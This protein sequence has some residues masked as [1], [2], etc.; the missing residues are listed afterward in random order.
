LLSK[1]SIKQD[2][3]FSL[4]EVLLVLALIGVM[5]AIVAGNAGAFIQA[6]SFEPPVRV[7]KKAV[8]D[9]YYFAGERK[10]ATFL[11]YDEENASFMVSDVSGKILETHSVFKN[12]NQKDQIESDDFPDVQF[13]AV[14]PLSGSS[15]GNTIY[16]ENQLLLNRIRFHS[17]SSVAFEASIRHRGE[18]QEF[19]FD[20][21]SGF[22]LSEK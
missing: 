16:R 5:A 7:L 3:G 11:S 9:A 2:S 17:G 15:G 14:G 10:E 4:I 1:I 8:L 18:V 12:L 13:R 21:F 6:G 20:P 22:V 19:L